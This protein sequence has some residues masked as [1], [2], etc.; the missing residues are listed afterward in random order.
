MTAYV[1]IVQN[2]GLSSPIQPVLMTPQELDEHVKARSGWV[3]DA[4]H[5]G[6]ILYD[7]DGTIARAK[8]RLI[9]EL[10]EK[11]VKRTEYGWVWPIKAGQ[12]VEL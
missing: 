4:L 1:T 12:T 3:M 6:I 11:G 8:H 9:A 10:K 7:P 2:H 5:E